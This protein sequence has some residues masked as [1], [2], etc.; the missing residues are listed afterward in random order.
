MKLTPVTVKET[1]RSR[2]DDTQQLAAKDPH[3]PDSYQMKVWL[4]DFIGD[5]LP[6][7][8]TCYVSRTSS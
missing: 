3:H 2:G 4:L 7:T 5:F 1:K 6:T 8:H